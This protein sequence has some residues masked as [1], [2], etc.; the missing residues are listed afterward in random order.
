MATRLEVELEEDA[1]KK[2]ARLAAGSMRDAMTYLDQ[3]Y[4]MA[5]KKISLKNVNET[6]GL[7]SDSDLDEII[8][9][10][11]SQNR[12]DVATAINHAFKSGLSSISI[13][14]SLMTRLRDL[15]F[16]SLDKRNFNFQLTDNFISEIRRAIFE[17][18]NSGIPDI[19]LEMTLMKLS[20]PQIILAP[21][22][23]NLD[24][25]KKISYDINEVMNTLPK[26]IVQFFRYAKVRD[27]T[28]DSVT[29]AFPKSFSGLVTKELKKEFEDFI[30]QK[31]NKKITAEIFA[32]E[33][34]KI[35]KFDNV[36][37]SDRAFLEESMNIFQVENFKIDDSE[38]I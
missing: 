20:A 15:E 9:A 11:K 34:L 3:C 10:V 18:Q 29:L 31:F 5:D 12:A 21:Q 35:S 6:L 27:F 30:S 37:D 7:V 24:E 8:S 13:A 19:I 32:D 1:A 26:S 38:V 23:A 2:I 22:I 17:M 25:S 16:E 28:G 36:K 14:E 33:N 4:A